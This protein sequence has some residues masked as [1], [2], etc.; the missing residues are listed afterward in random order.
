[1]F[2]LLFGEIE[3]GSALVANPHIKAVGFTGSRGGGVALGRI[4]AARPEPI[5]VYAEMSSINPVYLLPAAL[6]ARADALGREFVA[7]LTMGAGQ[8]CTNPG[9]VF[10]IEGSDLDRFL[11]AAA[12]AL[13]VCEPQPMLTARHPQ[14]VRGRR[15][16]SVGTQPG[17]DHRARAR[18]QGIA[19]GTGALFATDA[20]SF[21]ADER[22]GHEVFGSSSLVVRCP[23][24]DTLVDAFGAA[25][26][27][28][29]RDAADGAGRRW[30]SRGG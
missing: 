29:D 2:S 23:D 7:S 15:P 3:T 28:A 11:D 20:H 1:M 30:R 19:Q 8:F 25:R 14:G 13:K 10:G 22:L 12:T 5:P 26:R 21:M 18:G 17:R 16:G 6:S 4:A 24:E 9:L 27:P